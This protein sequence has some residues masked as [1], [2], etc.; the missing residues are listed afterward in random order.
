MTELLFD[1][2]ELDFIRGFY[3]VVI[4]KGI[5]RMWAFVAYAAGLA[6][7]ERIEVDFEGLLSF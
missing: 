3:P 4:T 5:C 7:G 1:A 2:T 6:L